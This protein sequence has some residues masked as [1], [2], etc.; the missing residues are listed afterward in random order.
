MTWFFIKG[1]LMTFPFFII[2]GIVGN[3]IGVLTLSI[4]TKTGHQN[5]NGF[6]KFSIYVSFIIGAFFFGVMGM[7]Y[8]SYTVLLT[9]YMAKWL[10]IIVVTLLL[11][12]ISR[13]TFKEVRSLHNKTILFASYEFYNE[14]KYSRH[15]Q[16]VNENILLGLMLLLPSY[17]FFL[18]FDN[19]ADKIFMGLN[20]YL[21]SFFK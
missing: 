10:A 20:S 16:V 5:I 6:I 18:I 3:L 4:F 19:L 17:I 9:A 14:G 8:A 11:I 1:V 21:I 15:S 7:F 13:Y 2:M 12:S